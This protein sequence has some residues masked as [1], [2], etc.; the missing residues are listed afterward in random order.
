VET[1]DTDVGISEGGDRRLNRM[2]ALTVVV[3][4]IFTAVGQIKDGNIVQAMEQAQSNSVDRWNQYQAE[5][6]KLHMDEVG[7]AQAGLVAP[8]VAR[9]PQ[10]AALLAQ[11]QARLG[12]EIAKYQ[13]QTPELRRKAEDYQAQYDALN[14]HDD[15]FDASEAMTG[16]AISVAGVAALTEMAGLLWLSWGI[17]AVGIVM[18]LA[19]F[20]GLGLHLD[21]LARLLG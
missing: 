9:E 19:G 12:A 16:I 20:F 17:G 21:A 4:S 3:L 14:V 15:Q 11:E 6:I 2:V 7:L 8:L 10:A 18:G 13:M 1:A 5:R